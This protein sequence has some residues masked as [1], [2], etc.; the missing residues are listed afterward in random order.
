MKI[1]RSTKDKCAVKCDGPAIVFLDQAC[2]QSWIVTVGKLLPTTW[3]WQSGQSMWATREREGGKK[4]SNTP[5]DQDG[6][7]ASA[8]VLPETTVIQ[9]VSSTVQSTTIDGVASAFTTNTAVYVTL[10]TVSPPETDRVLAPTAV[11]LNSLGQP[12]ATITRDYVS[13][14]FFFLY[15]YAFPRRIGPRCLSVSFRNGHELT[16]RSLIRKLA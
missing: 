2:W 3:I 14:F 5:A 4:C 1:F 16:L 9:V 7:S 8:S 11:V 6:S 15:A 10:T 13:N 12:V